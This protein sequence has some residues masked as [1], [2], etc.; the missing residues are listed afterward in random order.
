MLRLYIKLSF[1][2]G[3]PL[4][5]NT[6]FSCFPGSR[7]TLG[8]GC[9][10][11]SH[12][13]PVFLPASPNCSKDKSFHVR[14]VPPGWNPNCSCQHALV[15]CSVHLPGSHLLL[16]SGPHIC[17]PPACLDVQLLPIARAPGQQILPSFLDFPAG[18]FFSKRLFILQVWHSPTISSS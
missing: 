9:F 8:I 5:L 1:F 7:P 4:I 11:L 18:R 17:Q 10:L 3:P 16:T 14:P 6:S 12:F 13:L 15:L 2:S